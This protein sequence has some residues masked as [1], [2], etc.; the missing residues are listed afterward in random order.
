MKA[1]ARHRTFVQTRRTRD[2]ESDPKAR[3]DSVV[4]TRP[5]RLISFRK[6]SLRWVLTVGRLCVFGGRQH[7]GNLCTFSQFRYEP[8]TPPKNKVYYNFKK[9]NS[10]KPN[11]I[12]SYEPSKHTDGSL[13]EA[14]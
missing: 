6:C 5:W 9:L 14:G 7:A 1:G 12:R 13:Q 11:Q 10:E 3:V 2:A 4:M 8:K